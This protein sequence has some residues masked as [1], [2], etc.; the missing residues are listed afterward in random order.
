MRIQFIS[1]VLL[2]VCSV[3]NGE[4]QSVIEGSPTPMS[5]ATD[6]LGNRILLSING[7]GGIWLTNDGGQSWEQINERL[8]EATIFRINSRRDFLSMDSAAD[9]LI[10]NTVMHDTELHPTSEFHSYDGGITWDSF[11]YVVNEFWPDS[12]DNISFGGDP[13]FILPDRAYYNRQSGFCISHDNGETWEVI[14]LNPL[15]CGLRGGLFS[16]VHPDTVYLYGSWGSDVWPPGPDTVG[17]VLASYDGGYNWQRILPIEDMTDDEVGGIEDLIMG[18]GNNLY[19]LAGSASSNP[20]PP[21]LRSEDRG[22]TWAW[23]DD[24]GLPEGIN[25]YR[26][27]AV[28]EHPGRLIIGGALDY[29]VWESDDHGESWHRLLRGLP[30]IPTAVMNMYRNP[31]SGHLY[32]LLQHYGIYKSIDH[33]DTWQPVPTPQLGCFSRG[34]N[35]L[36]VGEGG[37]IQGGLRPP[38]YYASDD[39]TVFQ[40]VPWIGA[41]VDHALSTYSICYPPDTLLINSRVT[42]ISTNTSISNILMSD[43]DG[44]SWTVNETPLTY[45]QEVFDVETDSGLVLVGRENNNDVLWYSF[46]LGETWEERD[47]PFPFFNQCEANGSIFLLNS[48]SPYDLY[49]SSDIGITWEPLGFPDGYNIITG[50]PTT[51]LSLDDALY[52]RSS[53]RCWALDEAGVWQ[54]RGEIW[55][56]FFRLGIINWDIVSTP[57]DTFIIAA[58]DYSHYLSI[59]HDMG[60][61]WE[62]QEVV[63]PGDY[64]GEVGIDVAYDP[65]R[66]RLWV[67]TSFGLAYLDDPTTAVGEDVWVFQPATYATLS[68]YPNPFN[69]ATTVRYSLT[70]PGEVRVTVFDLLGREVAVL[71]DRMVTA[72][73]HEL[74]FDASDLSSG[75]YFL[76]LNSNDQTLTRKLTLVK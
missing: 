67:D 4:W 39:A 66:D 3:S 47:V 37:V 13:T 9:T 28:P 54:E 34:W 31:Y 18:A 42:D 26:V 63:L 35:T 30:E 32:I 40:P 56:Y 44:V 16:R 68:A 25:L 72:G 21:I 10:I 51:I 7:N 12:I 36:T 58:S 74:L 55:D 57:A 23:T 52:V 14:D 20:Y 33:G 64:H 75:T 69:A 22:Q 65:W 50:F 61:T 73:E 8:A 27:R 17:G 70:Q 29:G 45:L 59:S 48:N 2:M 15:E 49:R 71:H 6:S 41:D 62:E 24:R 38:L 43:N 11:T 76:K 1:I 19:A 53:N 5:I 46:D 60:W